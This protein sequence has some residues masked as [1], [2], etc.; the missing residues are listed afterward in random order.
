MRW[1]S[2]QGCASD[3]MHTDDYAMD[4]KILTNYELR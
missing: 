4:Y 1:Y 3:A 2:A